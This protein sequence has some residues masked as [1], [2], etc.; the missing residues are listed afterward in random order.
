MTPTPTPVIYP[1]KGSVEAAITD[2]EGVPYAF[3]WYHS[4]GCLVTPLFPTCDGWTCSIRMEY[5][6]ECLTYMGRYTHEA[7][8]G[9]LYVDIQQFQLDTTCPKDFIFGD[10]FED[11]TTDNWSKT[12]N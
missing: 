7:A 2:V 1:C 5:P 11:G 10:G 12:I 6:V 3:H 9:Y 4:P 8:P